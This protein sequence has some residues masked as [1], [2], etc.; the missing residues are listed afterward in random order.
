MIPIGALITGQV[1]LAVYGYGLTVRGLQQNT[2]MSL[3]RLE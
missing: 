2:R 1:T 3:Q